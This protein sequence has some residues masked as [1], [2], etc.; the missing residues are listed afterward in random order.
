MMGNRRLGL[1]EISATADP[2]TTLRFAQDDRVL[3]R[4]RVRRSAGGFAG[5]GEQGLELRGFGFFVDYGGL[6]F[7]ESGILQHGFDFAFAE[8][9]STAA[10]SHA[11]AFSERDGDRA[12]LE[13][14]PAMRPQNSRFSRPDSSS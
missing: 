3:G 8:S 13:L 2:S 6:D 7:F 5:Y 10:G 9:R 1:L 14:K 4:R 11:H 12:S